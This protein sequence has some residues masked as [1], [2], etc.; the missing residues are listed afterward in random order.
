[1]TSFT[2][3]DDLPV[4]IAI[5]AVFGG[6]AAIL[7]SIVWGGFWA[8]LTLSVL[9]GWFAAPLFGLPLLTIWQAYGLVLVARSMRGLAASEKP[10]DAFGK[11]MTKALLV[12]PFACGLM[13]LTGWAV[14]D[15]G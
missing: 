8:G 2:K 1:M 5:A 14:K 7:L 10:A 9:W 4:G 15:W 12:P 6:F 3:R 13:L 11:A